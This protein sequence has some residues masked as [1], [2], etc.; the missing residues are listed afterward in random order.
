MLWWYMILYNVSPPSLTHTR[1]HTHTHT[2]IATPLYTQTPTPLPPQYVTP[3]QDYYESY[4]NANIVL[5]KSYPP[6][7]SM[8]NRGE[9]EGEVTV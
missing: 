8:S 5:R 4:T 7:Y 2:R 6:Q 3:V 1:T 9:V